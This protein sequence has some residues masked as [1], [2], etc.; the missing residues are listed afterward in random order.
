MGSRNTFINAATAAYV[1][2]ATTWILLSDALLPSAADPHAAAALSTVKGMFFVCASAAGLYVALR[3][4]PHQDANTSMVGVAG[5]ALQPLSGRWLLQT[6]FAA[7]FTLAAVP[8]QRY[9]PTA[10]LM[11]FMP[12]IIVS[13]AIGGLGPG[14]LATL[15]AA[16]LG[17]HP[18][19]SD[20]P[21]HV[22]MLVLSGLL[23]SAL[24]AV[25]RASLRDAEINGQ[26][27]QTTIDATSDGLWDWDLENRILFQTGGVA[28]LSGLPEKN[29]SLRRLLHAVHRD[30]RPS[31]LA[32]LRLH[33]AGKK[34]TIGMS[35]RFVQRDG[36]T[37]WVRVSGRVVA[38]ADNG[39][40]TRMVG[41]LSDISEWRELEQMQRDADT[42]FAGTHEGIMVVDTHLRIERVNPAFERITGYRADEV[43]GQTPGLLASG[44]HSKAFYRDMWTSVQRDGFWRGEIWNARKNGSV[45]PELLTISA[46]RD[47]K[48]KAD[49]YIGVFS[50]ISHIKAHA[51]ELDRA[52]NFD[53]LTGLP[54]RRLL[55]DRFEHA[56]QRSNRTGKPLTVCMLDLD[57]FKDVNQCHGKQAGDRLLVEIAKS[58]ASVVRA[59]D[60]LARTGGDEFVLLM[61]DIGTL[62]ECAQALDRVL[63]AASVALQLGSETIR[64]TASVG[65]CRYPDDNGNADTLLR[66]AEQ[67][68]YQA[69][70]DGRGRYQL[71][72][73]VS[74]RQAQAHRQAMHRLRH[75][76]EQEEFRLHYQPK[77]DLHTGVLVGVEALIRWQHPE[78]GLLPPGD[79]LPHVIGTQLETD[80]GDWVIRTALAQSAQWRRQGLQVQVSVNVGAAQLLAPGFS[81]SL[82]AAL[83]ACPGSA[84]GDLELEVL[85][86]AAIEDVSHA[87]DVLHRCHDMGVHFALD[88][89]GTGYSSLTYLR[90]LPVD[91]LKVDQSFVRNMLSDPA[92]CGIVAGVLRMA[93]AMGLQVVAEGVETAE[94]CALL[95]D[96]GCELAQGYG[97]ARPMAPELLP[98]WA[99][100][101]QVAA[102]AA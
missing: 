62:E 97:I 25:L 21:L 44:R 64:V 14:A 93:H 95:S 40:A 19:A 41:T 26:R 94:H 80:I 45:Y 76:L 90:K 35:F 78:R 53:A 87:M 31:L 92:D 69:K 46:V 12:C 86:T 38:Q 24:C 34:R 99:A 5:A 52:A 91:T 88:D 54:N 85:E 8:L 98:A 6:L 49:H 81:D 57:D 4:V 7:A 47:D 29:P 15:L 61:A 66:H 63:S 68:M 79:F 30:D 70:D 42:V 67:A 74:D 2:G 17:K 16:V 65:V 36:S 75:A 58:L 72:D 55:T 18:A 22:G 43:V 60:T 9:L 50:D 73:P 28:R 32:Q 11:L 59:D 13:A 56:I 101:R 82:E 96:M 89:F 51:A 84:P 20:Y 100:S 3:A 102:A 10:G 1:A 39:A 37:V 23:I 33:L 83:A 77:V 27:L 71:F 48:G